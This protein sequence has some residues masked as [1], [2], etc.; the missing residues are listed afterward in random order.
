MLLSIVSPVVVKNRIR[1]IMPLTAKDL[2]FNT[3]APRGGGE[4][5]PR[6]YFHCV[7]HA[8]SGG[9]G[10]VQI[11]CQNVYVLNGRS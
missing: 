2:P 5:K 6:I 10:G 7:L 1:E 11:A 9:G 3:Y 4:I 8:K